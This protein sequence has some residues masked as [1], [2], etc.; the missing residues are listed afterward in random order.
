[1]DNADVVI[2][3]TTWPA[4][5]DPAPLATALVTE[6]LAVCVNVL[7]EMESV[8][9]WRGEVQRERERQVLIKTTRPRLQAVERRLAQLHPYDVPEFLVFDAAGGSEAYIA[10]VRGSTE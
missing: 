2:V 7:A 8:F 4:A 1:M 6:R 9:T 10:W 3:L 5:S